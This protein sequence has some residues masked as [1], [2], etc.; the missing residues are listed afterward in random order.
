MSTKTVSAVIGSVLVA[1][2]AL[3]ALQGCGS[4]SRSSGFAETCMQGCAKVVSCETQ[5]GGT[6]T[7]AQCVQGCTDSAKTSSGG[8]CTNAAA[9][10]SAANACLSMTSCTALAACAASI[11]PCEGG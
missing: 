6:E 9:M 3:G 1:G 10:Q 8:T 4:S 7:M 5:L 11:P 2:F